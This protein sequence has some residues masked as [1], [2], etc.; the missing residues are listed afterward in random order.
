[1]VDSKFRDR[2]IYLLQTV[3]QLEG[4]ADDVAD[5]II[6]EFEFT[7][8]KTWFRGDPKGNFQHAVNGW[9]WS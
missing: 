1:M 5:A 8:N 7:E 3:G 2:L 9:M 6:A 4:R